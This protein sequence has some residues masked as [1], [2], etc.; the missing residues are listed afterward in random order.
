MKKTYEFFLNKLQ[1]G[2][3]LLFWNRK[4]FISKLLQ[5]FLKNSHCAIY[6]GNENIIHQTW[7][8]CIESRLKRYLQCKKVTVLRYK[9]I[10]E[11]EQIDIVSCAYQ[12][13][14]DKV[15]YDIKAYGGFTPIAIIEKVLSFITRKGIHISA[16][17][18]NPYDDE[19]KEVCSDNLGSWFEENNL[20]IAEYGSGRLTPD[21]ILDSDKLEIIFNRMEVKL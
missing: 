14:G 4:N 21:H 16:K 11:A 5:I 18:E 7:P 2:D 8:I 12:D 17:I 20:K 3:I 1:Y 13:V 10:T 15:K 19:F 9:E 6:A